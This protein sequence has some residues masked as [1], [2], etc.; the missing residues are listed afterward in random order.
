[1]WNAGIEYTARRIHAENM[2]SRKQIWHIRTHQ[3]SLRELQRTTHRIS[4][5]YPIARADPP[6]C[7]W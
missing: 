5:I 4:A 7:W 3:A 1:M 2:Q 6:F